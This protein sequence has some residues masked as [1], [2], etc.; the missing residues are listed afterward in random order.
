MQA[1]LN[2]NNAENPPAHPPEYQ[3][4]QDSR[5]SFMSILTRSRTE[6]TDDPAEDSTVTPVEEQAPPPPTGTGSPECFH[7][8]ED[9]KQYSYYNLCIHLKAGHDLAAKDSCG[10]SDPYVKFLIN[11]KIVYKSKTV[12]KDLNPFW[13]EKFEV[14]IEDISV[15]MDIKVYS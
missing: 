5:S 7:S 15:P 14:M 9:L 8:T 10:T 13:D 11:S 1:A 2:K 3:V 6:S 4:R 12:Y